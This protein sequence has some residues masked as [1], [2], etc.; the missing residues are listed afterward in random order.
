M[1][2]RAWSPGRA[3]TTGRSGSRPAA[4]L[5]PHGETSERGQPHGVENDHPGILPRPCDAAQSLRE[6]VSSVT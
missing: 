3:P 5:R 4:V 6:M 2:S 1:G